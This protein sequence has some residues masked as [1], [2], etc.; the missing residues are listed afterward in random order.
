MHDAHFRSWDIVDF[1]KPEDFHSRHITM[2][3][4][5]WGLRCWRGGGDSTC[6]LSSQQFWA[7]A[8]PGCSDCTRWPALV[9]SANFR[10]F[11]FSQL[12]CH[13]SKNI[14]KVL[15][16]ISQ[17]GSYVLKNTGTVAVTHAN[18]KF[19]CRNKANVNKSLPLKSQ[20]PLKA[21]KT[22]MVKRMT[23][24]VLCSSFPHFQTLLSSTDTECL[25]YQTVIFLKLTDCYCISKWILFRCWFH[26]QGFTNHFVKST[27]N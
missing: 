13:I 12:I 17:N 1:Q 24:E 22:Q 27:Y 25:R 15:S 16:E 6:P 19:T 20:V 2:L 26:S 23:V 18:L 5:V 21:C 7:F 4:S 10:R 11:F 8:A 9:S 14:F 3:L